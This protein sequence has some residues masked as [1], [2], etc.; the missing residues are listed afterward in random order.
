M[1]TT[2]HLRRRSARRALALVTAGT[3][4][5]GASIVTSAGPAA[6]APPGA[7]D[8]IRAIGPDNEIG[9]CRV[10]PKTPIF[11]HINP[12]GF[13]EYD[14]PINFSCTKGRLVKVAHRPQ[15]LKAG[16]NW[17]DFRAFTWHV[18]KTSGPWTYRH[19]PDVPVNNLGTA[20]VVTV[21]NRLRFQVCELGRD[22]ICSEDSNWLVSPSVTVAK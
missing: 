12:Q 20:S 3:A 8:D 6:A 15:W 19:S 4:L 5:V 2:N 22:S 7:I 18:T 17:V 13:R 10:V 14:F 21:R 11:S 16:G 9:G 1:N